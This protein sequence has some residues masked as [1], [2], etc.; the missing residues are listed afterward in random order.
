MVGIFF[1]LCQMVKVMFSSL[2]ICMSLHPS[3]RLAVRLVAYLSVSIIIKWIFVKFSSMV[4]HETRNSLQHFCIDCYMPDYSF[5]FLKLGMVEVCTHRVHCEGKM[6]IRLPYFHNGIF[7]IGKTASLYQT[8]PLVP[9][10][11]KLNL[12]FMMANNKYNFW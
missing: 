10:K 2:L 5:T 3:I 6:V 11:A 1:Y 9:R 7:Y 8:R 12:I 4:W